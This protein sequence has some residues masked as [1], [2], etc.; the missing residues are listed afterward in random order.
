[1]C[2]RNSPTIRDEEPAPTQRI[3]KVQLTDLEAVLSII[4]SLLVIYTAMR[5]L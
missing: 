3:G 4:A 1:L 5:G 2:T